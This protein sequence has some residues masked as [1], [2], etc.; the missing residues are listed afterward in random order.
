MA[1]KVQKFCFF[2][3]NDFQYLFVLSRKYRA[4][5]LPSLK[6]LSAIFFSVQTKSIMNV[7]IRYEPI[8]KHEQIQRQFIQ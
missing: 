3:A 7:I 5:Q 1:A 4:V 6:T 8:S 2:R